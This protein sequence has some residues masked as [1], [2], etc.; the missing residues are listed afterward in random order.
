MWNY[1]SCIKKNLYCNTLIIQIKTCKQHVLTA[2]VLN[3]SL[4]LGVHSWRVKHSRRISLWTWNSIF[5]S[6]YSNHTVLG[7]AK[8]QEMQATRSLINGHKIKD[9]G[10]TTSNTSGIFRGINLFIFQKWQN[11]Y[12][13][14]LLEVICWSWE[15][16]GTEHRV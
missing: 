6:V 7:W 10:K 13:Q 5:L 16:K 4:A 1:D 8:V 9:I 2:N 3:K 11:I 12:E 14:E 15:W